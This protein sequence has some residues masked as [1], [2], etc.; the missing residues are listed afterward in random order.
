[1]GGREGKTTNK[2]PPLCCCT[3][4]HC[5][6]NWS[7]CSAG[8]NNFQ[9]CSSTI[10]VFSSSSPASTKIQAFLTSPLF[11]TCISF[12]HHTLVL[13]ALLFSWTPSFFL[14]SSLMCGFGSTCS[15]FTSVLS[16]P[17][18]HFACQLLDK[19]CFQKA[20]II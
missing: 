17:P 15:S 18:S 3:W 14:V 7:Q 13:L 16:E 5:I 6:D 1:M 4:V 9:P 10:P 20:C 2:P 8:K 19:C 11:L 12:S